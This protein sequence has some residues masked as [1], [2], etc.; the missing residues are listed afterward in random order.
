MCPHLVHC[1]LILG[2]A[3][4]PVAGGELTDEVMAAMRPWVGKQ[5]LAQSQG[6]ILGLLLPKRLTGYKAVGSWLGG[7]GEG[8]GWCTREL[9]KQA[10]VGSPSPFWLPELL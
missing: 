1:E 6:Q 9:S 10:A 8:G 2:L 5:P 3:E 7:E 4:L